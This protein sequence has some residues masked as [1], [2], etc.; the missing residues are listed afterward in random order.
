M[1]CLT[2]NQGRITGL[3]KGGINS[4]RYGGALDFLAC[5]QIEFIQKP[6]AEMVRIENATIHHEFANL[7]KE[8]ERVT[9]ASFVAE[10]CLRLLEPHSPSRDMFVLLS[11]VLFQLDAHAPIP[12]TINAFL[13]KAFKI[14][15]YPPSL[16]RC[17]QCGRGAHEIVQ[18]T[19]SQLFWY[20]EAGGL[21]CRDCSQGRFKLELQPETLLYFQ[22]L[23]VAP[24]KELAQATLYGAD[25]PNAELYRLLVDFLHHHIP[26]LPNEGLKSWRLLNEVLVTEFGGTSRQRVES[27]NRVS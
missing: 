9:C 20:S 19:P 5:S 25:L 18:A 12:S 1:V 13:C 24:F 6:H 3:A 4:R 10:F 14:L 23:T 22:K 16:L 27:N 17:V 7:H 2:E 21:I 15:G 26:G 11:N 8:F